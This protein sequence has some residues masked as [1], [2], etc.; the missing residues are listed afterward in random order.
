MG[1]TLTHI[2]V[3]R[4]LTYSSRSTPSALDPALVLP[5]SRAFGNQPPHRA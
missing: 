1:K 3:S 5:W 4:S 2:R